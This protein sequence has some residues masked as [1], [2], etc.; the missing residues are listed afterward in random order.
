MP[1]NAPRECPV[2]PAPSPLRRSTLASVALRALPPKMVCSCSGLL[3]SSQKPSEPP[4]P[5]RP[6][7]ELGR[8]AWA[9]GVSRA[10]RIWCMRCVSGWG[11][12]MG[13]SACSG[14]CEG[15]G[16]AGEGGGKGARGC[17]GWWYKLCQRVGVHDGLV[18]VQRDL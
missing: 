7:E 6:S 8:L 9:A 4:I 3:Y 12:V 15:F 13:R 18:G 5:A 2:T 14:T 1:H 10:D 17:D 11:S 16:V